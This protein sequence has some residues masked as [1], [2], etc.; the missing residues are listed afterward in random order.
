[1]KTKDAFA[2]RGF[3]RQ[4]YLRGR[5]VAVGLLENALT[6]IA[7]DTNDFDDMQ[8]A[9]KS[10]VRLTDEV[11]HFRWRIVRHN[12]RLLRYQ[13]TLTKDVAR[14]DDDAYYFS[15]RPKGKRAVNLSAQYTTI[16]QELDETLKTVE[17]IIYCLDQYQRGYGMKIFAKRLKEARKAAGLTQAQMAA[18][19]GIK[20]A[21]Y[22]AY[23]QARHEPNVSVLFILS[24]E[25][26]RSPSWF[27]CF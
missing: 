10:Y 7:A 25:L 27:F 5:L 6:T 4:E 23:E 13:M 1:M 11:E 21:S 16:A 26:N 3:D 12:E 17:G 2:L 14:L 24:Q 20:Q 15:I 9:R 19:L 8:R 22:A 18:R